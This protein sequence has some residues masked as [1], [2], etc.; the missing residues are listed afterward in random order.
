MRTDKDGIVW[1]D[2]YPDQ[3]TIKRVLNGIVRS[4]RETLEEMTEREREVFLLVRTQH[5]Q[6]YLQLKKRAR[7]YLAAGST[8]QQ[9]V[10]KLRTVDRLAIQP[11]LAALMEHEAEV[12]EGVVAGLT[13]EQIAAQLDMSEERVK[14]IIAEL[15]N[16]QFAQRQVKERLDLYAAEHMWNVVWGPR[17]EQIL[18]KD[19]GKRTPAPTDPADLA[20]FHFEN[21]DQDAGNAAEAV[22][23]LR[24][25]IDGSSPEATTESFCELMRKFDVSAQRLRKAQGPTLR[26]V[27]SN[28]AHDR[29]AGDGQDDGGDGQDHADGAGDAG[30]AVQKGKGNAV[31]S[32]TTDC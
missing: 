13:S 16:E 6:R 12:A 1:P 31:Q 3:K 26:I 5:M 25:H 17:S 21:L 7:S 10:E 2:D 29:R 15:E 18:A 32:R 24:R 19:N 27:S 11:E 20:L 4:K 22:R 8:M 28:G 14:R 30:A 9:M 23:F